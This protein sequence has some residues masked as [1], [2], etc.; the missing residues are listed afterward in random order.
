MRKNSM[1]KNKTKAKTTESTDHAIQTRHDNAR[2]GLPNF[3]KLAY[4]IRSS[5]RHTDSQIVRLNSTLGEVLPK[6]K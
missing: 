5:S 4:R 2:L 6:Q 1:T 3:T